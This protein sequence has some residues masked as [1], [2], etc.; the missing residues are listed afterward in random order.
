MDFRQERRVCFPST[1]GRPA[2]GQAA[3]VRQP[4]G[5]AVPDTCR[6]VEFGSIHNP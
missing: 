2:S 3:G 5:G 1:P 4:V 6:M